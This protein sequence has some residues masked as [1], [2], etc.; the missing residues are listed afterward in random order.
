MEKR[1]EKKTFKPVCN[2]LQHLQLL[3]TMVY[4]ISYNCLFNSSL[5]L[6]IQWTHVTL[7][8]GVRWMGGRVG[9]IYQWSFFTPE[10]CLLGYIYPEMVFTDQLFQCNQAQ[11]KIIQLMQLKLIWDWFVSKNQQHNLWGSDCQADRYSYWL[12]DTFSS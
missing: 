3:S 4:T 2:V 1:L 11:S 6:F 8:I 7:I 12:L 5:Q 10:L 9:K